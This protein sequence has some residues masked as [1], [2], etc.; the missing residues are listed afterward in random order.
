VPAMPLGCVLV[1]LVFAA[2]A[3]AVF[4]IAFR[5]SVCNSEILA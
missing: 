3:S 1:V 4:S 2:G 5:F